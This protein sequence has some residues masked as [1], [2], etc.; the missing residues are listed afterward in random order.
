MKNIRLDVKSL[1]NYV[2]SM[3][4][5]EQVRAARGWLG[6]TQQELAARAEIGLSTLRAFE[7][8]LRAPIRA[9]RAA[10]QRALENEGI[11]L[12]FEGKTATGI[13]ITDPGGEALKPA[14]ADM[15]MGTGVDE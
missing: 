4:T 11:R 6:L 12:L 9:N 7:A 3:I 5:A 10:L 13:T 1:L 8:G 15:P 14:R 2:M